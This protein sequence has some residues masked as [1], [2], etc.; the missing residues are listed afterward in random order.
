MV[1]VACPAR[2]ETPYL[3]WPDWSSS[4]G[5]AAQRRVAPPLGAGE[6]GEAQAGGGRGDVPASGTGMPL[7]IF[8]EAGEDTPGLSGIAEE[9][10]PVAGTDNGTEARETQTERSA[11]FE[12]DALTF[13]DQMYSAALRMTRNPA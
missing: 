6:A 10:V 4:G 7:G 13:L 3:S 1:S 5:G 12:R 11:R 8:S 2:A 9:V